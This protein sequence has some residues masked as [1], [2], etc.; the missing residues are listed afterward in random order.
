MRPISMEGFWKAA[1]AA[2]A[3]ACAAGI[4]FHLQ[5]LALVGPESSFMYASQEWEYYG[6]QMASAGAAVAAL[7]WMLKSRTT[8]D[9]RA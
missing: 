8:R 3:A 1:V 2:G 6:L 5:G 4:V 7:A 9:R